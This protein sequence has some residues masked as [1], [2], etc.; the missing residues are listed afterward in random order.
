MTEL[1]EFLNSLNPELQ[2]ELIAQIET[3]LSSMK[4]WLLSIGGVGTAITIYINKKYL[5]IKGDNNTNEAKLKAT[6]NVGQ[7]VAQDF[8]KLS[9]ETQTEVT[10]LKKLFL[11]Q[12]EMF[13]NIIKGMPIDAKTLISTGEILNK[14]LEITGA[15]GEKYKAII[16][17]KQA[18]QLDI[19]N[20]TD[21]IKG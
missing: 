1:L 9:N 17:E 13:A 4:A 2:A 12:Q 7:E 10:E 8:I 3:F 11:A 6:V 20:Y 5:K 21:T 19:P 16:E 15:I 18:N 14:S